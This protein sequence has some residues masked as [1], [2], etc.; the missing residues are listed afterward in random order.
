[1]N[2]S[3]SLSELVFLLVGVQKEE[4]TKTEFSSPL[5][6]LTS[7]ETGRCL[8]SGFKHSQH[9]VRL[10]RNFYAPLEIFLNLEKTF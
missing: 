2:L 9:K 4:L 6:E 3:P 10:I 8:S 5:H 1:M 7:V